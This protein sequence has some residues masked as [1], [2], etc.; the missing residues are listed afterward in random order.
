MREAVV[1]LGLLALAGPAAA[2]DLALTSVAY[3]DG[4]S[5]GLR[6]NPTKAAPDARVDAS[7]KYANGRA[8]VDVSYRKLEPALLFGGD[9]G[10]YVVWAVSPDGDAENIGEIGGTGTDGSNRLQT[11]KR[12]FALLVTAEPRLPRRTTR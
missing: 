12:D 9:I 2:A 6:L 10:A 1:L 3:P 5:V 8:A 11:R 4:T 7:V